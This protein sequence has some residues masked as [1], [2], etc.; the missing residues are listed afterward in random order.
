MGDEEPILVSKSIEISDR[1][2]YGANQFQKDVKAGKFP[3]LMH[4]GLDTAIRIAAYKLKRDGYKAEATE[5]LKEWEDT[6]SF[7]YVMVMS[8]ERHIGDFEPVSVWL[9]GKTDML[10]L[11]LGAQTAYNLRLSDLA[12]FN[13]TPIPVIFCRGNLSEDEY[14]LHW[15]H[16]AEV[17][18]RGLAPVTAFWVSTATCLGA[19]LSTG[20][21]FCSPICQGIEW[22][23]KKYVAPNTNR[24][25]WQRA[26]Q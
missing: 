17:Y 23:V 8:G 18:K 20:F 9:K 11:L 14:R 15:V 3:Q 6:Y 19:S 16:D 10:I 21:L 1:T 24:W 7:E 4:H 2:S 22:L 25:M 12:S 13:E 5:L 26:C